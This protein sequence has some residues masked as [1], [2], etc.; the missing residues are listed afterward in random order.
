MGDQRGS[1]GLTR[2]LPTDMKGTLL[3]RGILESPEGK[4]VHPEEDSKPR[5]KQLNRAERK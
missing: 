3:L 4:T 2:S 5:P 1:D